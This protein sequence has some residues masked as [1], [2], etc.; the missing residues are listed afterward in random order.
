MRR[1][2]CLRRLSV[3]EVPVQ[4]FAL[5]VALAVSFR[6]DVVIC[7]YIT[8]PPTTTRWTSTTIRTKT[9]AANAVD[10][11]RPFLT[12]RQAFFAV[13][14]LVAVRRSSQEVGHDDE[15]DEDDGPDNLLEALL[16]D[17]DDDE[18]YDDEDEDALA[19][20]DNEVAEAI[21][22]TNNLMSL[23]YQLFPE[24]QDERNPV[25]PSLV[26]P[27]KLNATTEHGSTAV[28][29]AAVDA[30]NNETIDL[31]ADVVPLDSLSSDLSYFY[32]RNE[33]GLPEDVMWKITMQAP[34]VLGMKSSNI[35]NKVAVLKDQ[36]GLSDE[37]VR[38]LVTSQPNV[39]KLS[40]T[41][42]LSPTIFFLVRQLALGKKELRTLVLGCPS[43]LNYSRLN[44]HR[45]LTFFTQTMGFSV[46]ECRKLL[47][48][49][50]MVLTASVR[51]GLIPRLRFLHSE[52]EI[53]LPDLR[54]II[55]KNP[56][57]LRMSVDQN[58]QPKIIFF[59]IMTLNMTPKEVGKLLVKG[60][61][62][63]NYNLERRLIPL[64]EYFLS[65]NFSS[66]EFSRILLRFPAL[67]HFS[68]AR[69]KRRI[70]YLRFELGL[71]AYAVRRILHQSPQ[72]VSLSQENLE[73]KVEYLLQAVRPGATLDEE[74]E[75]VS[76]E[77][78]IYVYGDFYDDEED[79][80]EQDDD[81]D[82]DD[83]SVI[84][85][86]SKATDVKELPPLYIVQ[87]VISG[88]PSLL[89]LN[90]DGNL[91]P[92]VEFLR[93]CLGQEEFARTVVNF[94]TLLGYS[95]EKRI[96]PRVERMISSGVPLS[97]LNYVIVKTDDVFD[98][99]MDRRVKEAAS[100]QPVARPGRPR[101][102]RSQAIVP[103]DR[104]DNGAG[105]PVGSGHPQPGDNKDG[106]HK[107]GDSNRVVEDG[108][109][110]VHWRRRRGL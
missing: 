2:H 41:K 61:Q 89:N 64:H 67:V 18:F 70:G 38:Q 104:H 45:K 62:I 24:Q 29:I 57:L 66:H 108:G 71:D 83:D 21:L 90:V 59:F 54:R 25:S 80:E 35:R 79:D 26:P 107:N 4:L 36:I 68:M 30:P 93:D 109:R 8:A 103:R 88:L 72:V 48:Q 23:R 97:K 76:G 53:S 74:D 14:R 1:R 11:L 73:T 87:T 7:W 60:P 63:L 47:L 12:L 34:Q 40:V 56:N 77:M 28:S 85:E 33:L 19:L 20:M 16:M 106:G 82:G 17:D 15:D 32:L 49:D 99:W 39:L 46:K 37:D 110:I 69:V 50:P 5:A 92:K 100:G 27:A 58:L 101:K 52:V 31:P 94:P 75:K 9:T 51:T 6:L 44:L 84:D 78:E 65:L 105:D 96:R 81:N 98:E 3:L 102:P 10:P 13:P 42:N 43:L 95:L 22:S 86:V 55:Q 91:R